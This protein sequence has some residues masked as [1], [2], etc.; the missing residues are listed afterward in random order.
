MNAI[1]YKEVF[2]LLKENKIWL[3]VNNGPKIYQ[4]PDY[5]DQKI[6]LLAQMVK[7][8]LKWVILVGLPI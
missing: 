2:P 6:F 8:T 3:G 1:T 4:A 7:N 5:Y